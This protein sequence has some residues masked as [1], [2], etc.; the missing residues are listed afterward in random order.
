VK[1]EEK[2]IVQ[3]RDLCPNAKNEDQDAKY[4]QEPQ[5][6]TYKGFRRQDYSKDDTKLDTSNQS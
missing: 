1:I 6:K 5:L 3:N 4:I 2:Q